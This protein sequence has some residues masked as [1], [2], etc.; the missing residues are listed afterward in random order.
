MRDGSSRLGAR[1]ISRS[2]GPG[3]LAPGGCR[4]KPAKRASTTARSYVLPPSAA[5]SSPPQ[6]FTF[7]Q[8]DLAKLISPAGLLDAKRFEAEVD[9]PARA[10]V[11]QKTLRVDILATLCTRLI[12]RLL[13]GQVKLSKA[14][15]ENL[16]LFSKLDFLPNDLRYTLAQALA[17]APNLHLKA[18]MTAPT[19]AKLLLTKM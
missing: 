5:T 11:C 8:Q 2:W 18:L 17:S 9:A 12:K 6:S 4:A 10:L 16:K 13:N 14:Q 19:L 15:L 1:V 3:A 7:I